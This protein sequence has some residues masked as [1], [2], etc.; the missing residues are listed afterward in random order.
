MVCRTVLR[1]A[2]SNMGAQDG[3]VIKKDFEKILRHGPVVLNPGKNSVK[4]SGKVGAFQNQLKFLLLVTQ[5]K[6]L[7]EVI[8]LFPKTYLSH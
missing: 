5:F 1:R 7:I 2:D 3:D 4:L 8:S 6:K